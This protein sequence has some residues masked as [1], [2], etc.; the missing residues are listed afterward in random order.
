MEHVTALQSV[1]TKE[2]L[3]LDHVP[4]GTIYIYFSI[5]E[6]RLY[7]YHLSQPISLNLL[8]LELAVYLFMKRVGESFL[9]IVVI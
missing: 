9:K 3:L 7:M 1:E 2:E 4:Q 6:N 8:V 5:S